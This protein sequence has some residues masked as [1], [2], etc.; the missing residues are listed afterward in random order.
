[1][2]KDIVAVKPLGLRFEDGTEGI[3]D[4]PSTSPFAAFLSR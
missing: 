4:S 2:L 3:V 1:M